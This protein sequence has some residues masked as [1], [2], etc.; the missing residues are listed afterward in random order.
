MGESCTRG[1]QGKNDREWGR[2]GA[3]QLLGIGA[4]TSGVHGKALADEQRRHKALLF[5]G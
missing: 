3:P 1:R 5:D 2:G 4:S